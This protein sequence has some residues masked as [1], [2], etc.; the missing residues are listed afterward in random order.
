MNWILILIIILIIIFIFII[1]NKSSTS[2]SAAVPKGSGGS[3]VANLSEGD[4]SIV[5]VIKDVN[6]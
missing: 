1:Y 6:S 3:T 4:S 5:V 2:M